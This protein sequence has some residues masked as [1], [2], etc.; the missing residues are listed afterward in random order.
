MPTKKRRRNI[1]A[2]CAFGRVDLNDH[3]ESYHRPRILYIPPLA[4]NQENPPRF[5]F[6]REVRSEWQNASRQ[7]TDS[8]LQDCDDPGEGRG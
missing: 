5:C 7:R 8:G 4:R 1:P 3:V 6:W 2:G